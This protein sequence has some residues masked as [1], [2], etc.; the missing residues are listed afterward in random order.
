MGKRNLPLPF[1]ISK[2][3]QCHEK[4]A[5]GG[6]AGEK[7]EN[8]PTQRSEGD[9]EIGQS[10]L[11]SLHGH[12]AATLSSRKALQGC[13][14]WHDHGALGEL[15]MSYQVGTGRDHTAAPGSKSAFRGCRICLPESGTSS[16]APMRSKQRAKLA[17][18]R[19]LK[20]P[21]CN[22]NSAFCSTKWTHLHH[23]PGWLHL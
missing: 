23:S 16:A 1:Q 9:T 3:Q 10:L 21:G 17:R 5:I 12:T 2:H 13:G 19:I 18:G 15:A 6:S 11:V 4:T 20:Q 7:E 8:L 14:G 22:F